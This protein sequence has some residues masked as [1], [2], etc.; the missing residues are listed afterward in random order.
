MKVEVNGKYTYETDLNLK[1]G[2]KVEYPTASWLRDVM[3]PTQTGEVTSLQSN[4][5]GY[6]VKIIRKVVQ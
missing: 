4:Y 1:V 6:C 3:G 5:N 2:D